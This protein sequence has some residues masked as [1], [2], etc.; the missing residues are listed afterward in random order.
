MLIYPDTPLPVQRTAVVSDDPDIPQKIRQMRDLYEYKG[1][2]FEEK[3]WNFYYQGKFMEDYE[4][5][6][7]WTGTFQRYFPTYHDLSIRQLR[8]YFTWR[9]H[10]RRGNFQPIATSMAYIYIYELLNGLALSRQ[11]TRCKRCG[12]LRSIS[13]FWFWRLRDAQQPPS[14][15]AGICD[16]SPFSPCPG[17]TIC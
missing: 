17:S 8:G 5:D 15:D 3:C 11:K 2:S 14:M 13:G 6:L 7:P 10:A 12:N 1:N 16:A 4:D 9:T